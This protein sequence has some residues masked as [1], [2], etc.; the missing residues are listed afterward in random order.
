MVGH[1]SEHKF[2]FDVCLSFASEQ[3]DYVAATAFALSSAGIRVFYD[4]YE[5][6]T[7]WGRDL[8]EHLDDVYQNAA[9]FCVVFLSADYARKLWTTH[10]R[11]SAQARALR[12]NVEYILPARFD[13]TDLPGLRPSVGFV[14]LRRISPEELAELIKEKL[15][16]HLHRSLRNPD[17]LQG[18][19]RARRIHPASGHVSQEPTS[20][21]VV[22]VN[23]GNKWRQFEVVF[24][25]VTYQVYF[26][27]FH[28]F[29]KNA[30]LTVNGES[31]S[32]MEKMVPG[33][34]L[35]WDHYYDYTFTLDSSTRVAAGIRIHCADSTH[36]IKGL[37]IIVGSQILYT[38]GSL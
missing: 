1:Q 10:E 5:T 22:L 24:S 34:L 13:D 20:D 6:S 9:R 23:S 28:T 16:Y 26:E 30:M 32:M 12:E 21:S 15:A 8:Y 25:G 4:D 2:E 35:R 3:R 31:V 36:K 14:D 37:R 33:M 29:N 7:L 18:E 11:K 19:T 17:M 27:V 38:E